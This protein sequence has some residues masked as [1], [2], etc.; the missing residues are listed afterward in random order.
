MI[1]NT[2]P[3][4]IDYIKRQLGYPLI[5]IEVTDEQM[6]QIIDDVVQIFTE[7]A[8]GTLESTLCVEINGKG[9]YQL[10]RNIT[11]IIKLS[12][13]SVSNVMNFSANFGANYVPDLWSEQFFSCGLTS[14]IMPNVLSM[15]N[16]QSIFEKY[17]GDD[18]YFNFNPYKKV[19]QVFDQYKGKALLHF[20]YEYIADEV[21][22]IY[23]QMWIKRMCVS[24]TKFL[25]GTV[26]GKYSASLVGGATINYN[27]MKSE[28]QSEIDALNEELKDRWEDPAP[29]LIG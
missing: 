2:K 10:P 1:I 22:E 15:S 20:N 6:S 9:I 21:D 23:N 13:G 25:W 17:F 18:I 29:L 11:N 14:D 26:V 8:Y 4:L 12:R 24:K 5:E 27:D 16:T 7:I 28:A 19:L 3:L